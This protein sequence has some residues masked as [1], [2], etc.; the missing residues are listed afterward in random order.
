MPQDNNTKMNGFIHFIATECH[1]Y[2]LILIE[3]L[4]QRKLDKG[5]LKLHCYH[6]RDILNANNMP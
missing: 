2:L 5:Q 3:E 1:Q 6:L 4:T